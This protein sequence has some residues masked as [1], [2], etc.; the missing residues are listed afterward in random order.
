MSIVLFVLPVAFAALCVW[1]AVRIVNRR[2]RWAKWTLAVTVGVPVLY[3]LSFGPACWK[4]SR[5]D[6]WENPNEMLAI[7]YRP[8]VW[9]WHE[10]PMPI[11]GIIDWYANVGATCRVASVRGFDPSPETDEQLSVVRGF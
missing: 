7:V 5:F 4:F 3:V 6:G 1:L 11:G 10:R 2:E 9:I 8:I